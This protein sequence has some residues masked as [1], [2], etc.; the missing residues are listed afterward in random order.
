MIVLNA[1]LDQVTL[2]SHLSQPLLSLRKLP[3]IAT[4]SALTKRRH[5]LISRPRL[6]LTVT[7]FL[8]P[9]LAALQTGR[10]TLLLLRDHRLIEIF[11]LEFLI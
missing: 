5:R 7:D 2:E 1:T 9:T 4:N 6:R 3:P 11:F 10:N 8:L